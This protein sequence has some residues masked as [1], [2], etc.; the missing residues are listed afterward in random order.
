MARE[1]AQNPTAWLVS[2]IGLSEKA[3]GGLRRRE[4]VGSSRDVEPPCPPLPVPTTA[5]DTPQVG[6]SRAGAASRRARLTPG[7]RAPGGP[8]AYRAAAH[9]QAGSCSPKCPLGGT[10][11]P[12][13]HAIPG[14]HG[15]AT[16]VLRSIAVSARGVPR[17]PGSS[18]AEGGG[19]ESSRQSH[20]P[21]HAGLRCSLSLRGH[22]T[23]PR[24]WE[25]KTKEGDATVKDAH[26][27]RRP[28]TGDGALRSLRHGAGSWGSEHSVLLEPEGAPAHCECRA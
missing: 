17:Q 15:A 10:R 25:E 27:E 14:R 21:L 2:A 19:N 23:L 6:R 1:C 4:C 18:A 22:G 13:L 9:R 20:Q 7:A 26:P 3:N 5:R 8:C 12:L 11:P 24:P 28:T 16:T